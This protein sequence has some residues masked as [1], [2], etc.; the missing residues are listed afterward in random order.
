MEFAKQKNLPE[1]K[2]HLVPRTKGFKV[3]L[4]PMQGKVPAIYDIL[5]AFDH[6]DPHKPTLNNV[7]CGK[8]IVAHFYTR[9]IPMET[10][11]KTDAGKEK[12]LRDLF[13]DKVK[14]FSDCITKY[15]D[16]THLN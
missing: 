6:N 8:P 7:L 10:V 11:P 13:N 2:H 12:F 1:L 15:Y 9:R 5:L 4:P 16:V 3:T 14:V